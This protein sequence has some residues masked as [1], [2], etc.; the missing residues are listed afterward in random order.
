METL[1]KPGYEKIL[2]LFYQDPSAKIHL[3]AI[4]RKTKLNANS[5]S[6]FLKTLESNKIL[7]SRK[8]GNLKKYALIKSDKAYSIL[9][10]FDIAMLNTLQNIRKNAILYFLNHLIEKPIIAVLFGSTAKNTYTARSDIDLLLIVNKKLQTKAAE[11]YA[12]AQTAI[13]ISCFQITFREFKE[14]LRLKHDHVV[15]AAL[16]TG[17]PLTNHIEYYRAVNNESI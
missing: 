3:R 10:C 7:I 16:S 5:V 11:N 13:K 8:D 1:L 6:R 15:Q 17:Y 9:S 4:A 14:E 12:D 2:N